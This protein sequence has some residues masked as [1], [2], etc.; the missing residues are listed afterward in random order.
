MNTKCFFT[1]T[2]SGFTPPDAEI[3]RFL[4]A[5][6]YVFQD[7][8]N[9]GLL[10]RHGSEFAVVTMTLGDGCDQPLALLNIYLKIQTFLG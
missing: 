6:R 10:G 7:H 1:L 3:R 4:I 9:A 2:T 8:A 5:I